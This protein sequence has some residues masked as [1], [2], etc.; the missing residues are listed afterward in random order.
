ME[1][2]VIDP[3]YTTHVLGTI[4]S[5]IECKKILVFKKSS[6]DYPRLSLYNL[7]DFFRNYLMIN[8]E[9]YSHRCLLLTRDN[10]D[11]DSPFHYDCLDNGR[12]NGFDTIVYVSNISNTPIGFTEFVNAQGNISNYIDIFLKFNIDSSVVEISLINSLYKIKNSSLIKDKNFL[13]SELWNYTSSDIITKKIKDV[14]KSSKYTNH[15]SSYLSNVSKDNIYLNYGLINKNSESILLNLNKSTALGENF[16]N[17]EVGYLGDD[18]VVYAWYVDNEDNINFL[19]TSL[20]KNMMYNISESITTILPSYNESYSRTEILYFAGKYIVCALYKNNRSTYTIKLFDI[21]KNDWLRETK[22]DNIIVDSQDQFTKIYELPD[23]RAISNFDFAIELIPSINDTFLDLK[24][25]MEDNKLNLY[26]KIGEWFI[27]KNTIESS[28]IVTNMYCTIF[29]EPSDIEKLVVINN[30]A[31]MLLEDDYYVVYYGTRQKEYKTE[32]YKSKESG[33]SLLQ[34]E[35]DFGT[36]YFC[37]YEREVYENYYRNHEIEI[38]NKG[39]KLSDTIFN[40]Y[41]RQPI[42]DCLEVPDNII[43]AVGGI[44]FY[45]TL[46]NTIKFI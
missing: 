4:R 39:S 27:I 6:Y 23:Y 1:N 28:Y 12:I 15:L 32:R 13:G 33:L 11:S 34:E 16:D 3:G 2:L 35:F 43:G 40:F 44:I 9:D 7:D 38:V 30:S 24:T 36:I 22:E 5:I 21:L 8:N 19:V 37:N 17:L 20:T 26:R 14:Y 29:M 42:I 41:R 45:R 46:E 18:L 10:I 31:L 25:Y